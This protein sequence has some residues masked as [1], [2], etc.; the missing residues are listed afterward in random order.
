MPL[1][2]TGSHSSPAWLPL[3]P[4][5]RVPP[6]P[7]ES[8]ASNTCLSRCAELWACLHWSICSAQHNIHQLLYW[9]PCFDESIDDALK[10]P[11]SPCYPCRWGVAG[12]RAG[13]RLGEGR[14]AAE[15]SESLSAR[16]EAML[17]Q[18]H[19]VAY[20][21]RH[22]DSRKWEH[23]FGSSYRDHNFTQSRSLLCL[24]RA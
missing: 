11:Q 6:G 18:E 10:P 23:C 17:L 20:L 12:L 16:A 7:L 21:S 24:G 14:E 5:D 8:A 1:P 22:S 2:M 3:S 9:A 13:P 19:T 15:H 4:N